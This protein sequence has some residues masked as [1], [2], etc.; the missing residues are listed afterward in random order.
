LLTEQIV[1]ETGYFHPQWS[2]VGDLL[3]LMYLIR[4]LFGFL[5]DDGNRFSM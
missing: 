1:S 3:F 2:S 4:H 5:P